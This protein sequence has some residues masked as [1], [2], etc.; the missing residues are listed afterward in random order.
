MIFLSSNL[1][2]NYFP[3]LWFQT[4]KVVEVFFFSKWEQKPQ[5]LHQSDAH[6]LSY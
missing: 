1:N 2:D 6:D 3:F 5:P 4:C